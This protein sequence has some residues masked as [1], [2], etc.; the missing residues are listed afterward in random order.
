MHFQKLHK[1]VAGGGV[2]GEAIRV[3]KDTAANHETIY[4]GVF[5]VQF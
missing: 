4:F 1:F 5:G 2:V 3:G